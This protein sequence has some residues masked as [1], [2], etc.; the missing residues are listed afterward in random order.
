[1]HSQLMQFAGSILSILLCG[2]RKGLSTRNALLHFLE[3]LLNGRDNKKFAGAIL[4]E[5]SK[6]F[7]CLIHE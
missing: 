3:K 1:M 7:D 5:L 4:I 6:A 2:F